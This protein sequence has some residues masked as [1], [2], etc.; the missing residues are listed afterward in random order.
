MPPE[1]A[2]KR[3]RVESIPPTKEDEIEVDGVW[4]DENAGFSLITVDHVRFYVPA[5]HLQAGRSVSLIC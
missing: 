3:K 5:F 2:V 1:A 4:S